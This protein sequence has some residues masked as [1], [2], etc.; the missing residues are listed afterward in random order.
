MKGMIYIYDL[1]D[2]HYSLKLGD[3]VS[4]WQ[5][6][7]LQIY[8]TIQLFLLLFIG[9]TTLFGII[10]E[11]YYTIIANFYFYYNTFSKKFSISVK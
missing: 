3:E 4:V 2:N 6:L 11:F 9:P 10:Y 7:F 1:E 5:R 8:F